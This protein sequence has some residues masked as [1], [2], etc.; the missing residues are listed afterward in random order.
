MLNL[1]GVISYDINIEI[2][3]YTNLRFKNAAKY[4]TAEAIA[5]Y[6]QRLLDNETIL[7]LCQKQS[8]HELV[9]VQNAYVPSALIEKLWNSTVIP[10][11]YLPRTHELFVAA[12]EDIPVEYP[13]IDGA[14][15]K[16]T[17]VPI[18]NYF[19]LWVGIHG[20]HDDLCNIP[21]KTLI[22]SIYNEAIKAEAS[23]I[24]ISSYR[25]SARVYYNVRKNKV[26]SQRILTSN[27]MEDLI[28]YLT[29]ESPIA[30][31]T[32]NPKYV[33]VNLNENWRGRVVINHKYRG[34]VITIR[35]LSNELFNQTLEDC[36]INKPVI[37]FFNEY[38]NNKE[39]GL[40]IIAGPT[41]SGKNTTMLAILNDLALPDDMKIVSIEMPVEV[42]LPG[43]EQISCEDMDEFDANVKSLLRQNPDIV[44]I[45]ETGDTNARDVLTVANTGKRVFTTLHANGVADVISRLMDITSMTPDRII[46]CLHSI[47]YQNLVKTDDGNVLPKVA[48]CYLSKERK[49]QLYG[50]PLGDI[51]KLI[52]SWEGGDIW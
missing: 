16:I 18:Y 22:E 4:K 1:D 3:E 33:G 21:V 6:E 9:E 39:N 11:K 17:Y 49:N 34:Y 25:N 2:Q 42:E 32:N 7:E 23:D 27:D 13:L 14:E 38:F 51:I 50:K 28:K 24:T 30:D 10:Y 8:E 43:I 46:Q 29:F 48:F 15:L 12:C 5:L 45:S 20:Y 52:T 47:A 35:L 19:K 31:I 37:K 36:N 44:Y 26:Y 40:R 41:M